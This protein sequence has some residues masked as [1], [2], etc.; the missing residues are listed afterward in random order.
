MELLIHVLKL[1]NA[2][3]HRSATIFPAKIGKIAARKIGSESIRDTPFPTR[4]HRTQTELS[5]VPTYREEGGCS[6]TRADFCFQR[7][8]HAHKNPAE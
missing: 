5:S 6:K 7:S 2:T 8:R 1:E 3:V 4:V